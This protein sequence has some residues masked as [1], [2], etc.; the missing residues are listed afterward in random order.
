MSPPLVV[1]GD[2]G[3][4]GRRLRR[5]LLAQGEH[6]LGIG[7]SRPTEAEHGYEPLQLDLADRGGVRGVAERLR[8]AKAVF[9]LAAMLAT[10]DR[11]P[12]EP[13]LESNLRTTEN[14]L[15][16]LDGSGVPLVVS[17]TMSVFGQAPSSLPVREDEIPSPSGPYGLT[18]L[19][20]E[21]ACER[22]ARNGRVQC[23][24]LRY[25][26]IFGAGYHYGALHLY[27]SQAIAG[28]TISVY[29]GGRIIRDYVHVDDVVAANLLAADAAPQLGWGLF[30]IGGG[31]P[32][33]L[34]E[35][36]RLTTDALG[37]GTVE[38]NDE[39]G[40]FDFAFDISA[41]RSEL[42]YDPQPL[43]DRI[44]QYVDELRLMT[45]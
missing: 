24:V 19:A 13:H 34:A 27:A 40:P 20:S 35:I 23:V 26:G 4:V 2:R 31:E 30:H 16:A 12:L 10:S 42:G 5:H 33:A 17:S 43:A 44:Q 22:M 14:L 21:C 11:D 9:H 18:K 25:P 38:T 45:A 15:E 39:P 36:A 32:K 28:A 41:A 6:V 7:R 29:G 1:T 3:F 8:S 37:G